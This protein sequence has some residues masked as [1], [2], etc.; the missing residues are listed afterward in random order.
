M[1]QLEGYRRSSSRFQVCMGELVLLA[2]LAVERN[3]QSCRTS[4]RFSEFQ[5]VWVAE[6]S[7]FEA[8]HLLLEWV[9]ES[10]FAAWCGV[11]VVQFLRSVCRSALPTSPA[12]VVCSSRE[13]LA[14]ILASLLHL[15]RWPASQHAITAS[16]FTVCDSTLIP[17]LRLFPTIMVSS[18]VSLDLT[19][20]NTS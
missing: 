15:Q 1:G 20:A 10:F 12:R 11:V 3:S 19:L 8:L 2:V 7:S 13:R 14:R 6:E 9:K 18:S 4:G 5:E 17:S 16:T